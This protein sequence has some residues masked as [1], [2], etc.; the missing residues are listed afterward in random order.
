V[1]SEKSLILLEIL[2]PLAAILLLVKTFFDSRF[3][4]KKTRSLD[5]NLKETENNSWT[6]AVVKDL[7][8]RINARLANNEHHASSFIIANAPCSSM[9]IK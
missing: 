1:S 9:T 3:E 2:L 8:L 7:V 4:D 6:T 5:S